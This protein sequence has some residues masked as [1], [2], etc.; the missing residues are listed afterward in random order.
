MAALSAGGAEVSSE[1]E[2]RAKKG[3][4]QPRKSLRASIDAYCRWCIWDAGSGGGT[5]RQQV[6]DCT[7]ADCPLYPV[8]PRSSTDVA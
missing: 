4:R 1:A 5:W 3:P 8:R 7:A 2:K 6:T